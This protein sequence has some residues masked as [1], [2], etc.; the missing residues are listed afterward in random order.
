MVNRARAP[1]RPGSG[2]AGLRTAA[3]VTVLLLTVLHFAAPASG[4]I[5]LTPQEGEPGRWEKFTMTVPTEGNSPTA[6]VVL[7]V[8]APYEVEAI[9]HKVDWRVRA[10]RDGKGLVRQI[11][12]SGGGIPPLAFT[13]FRF[14]AKHPAA[15]G[16][17]QWEARQTYRDGQT[18]TWPIQTKVR[19]GGLAP[20]IERRLEGLKAMSLAA[21]GVAAALLVVVAALLVG[22]RR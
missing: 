13:E 11:I 17:Y 16:T 8:P 19:A 6:E 22:R 21:L 1:G 15:A 3:P 20:A 7:A 2:R 12:W 10:E 14:I 4:H 9:E 5:E 18:S